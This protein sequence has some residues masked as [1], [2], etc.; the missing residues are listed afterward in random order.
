MAADP[1][2]GRTDP[3]GRGS[4]SLLYHHFNPGG[5]WNYKDRFP[6]D[7]AGIKMK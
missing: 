6:G 7:T 4:A 3:G 2:A 5:D 1:A